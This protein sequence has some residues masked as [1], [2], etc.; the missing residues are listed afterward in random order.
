MLTFNDHHT[1]TL[2]HQLNKEID[3]IGF[4]VTSELSAGIRGFLFF[5]G[6]VLFVFLYCFNLVLFTLLPIMTLGLAGGV[7]GK[8]LRKE[9]QILSDLEKKLNSFIQEKMMQI[10]TVKLFSG[11]EIEMKEFQKQ[12]KMI[13]KQGV[14][15]A[16]IRS[17]FFAVMEFLGENTVIWGLGYGVYL[18]QSDP[19]LNIGKLT[20]FATYAV[21]AG[22]GYRLLADSLSEVIKAS[23]LYSNILKSMSDH[24]DTE[25]VF[26]LTEEYSSQV[27]IEI[28]ALSFTYPGRQV[29]VLSDVSMKVKPG[30]I[31]GLIGASGCG[32]STLFHLLTH[33][34]APDSGKILI[35]SI[36]IS[37]K[38]A[39]WARSFFSIVSQENLLFSN[40]ILENLRYSNPQA[41]FEDIKKACSRADALDFIENLPNKFETLVGENGFNLSGGQRQRICIAR[42]FLK[43]PKILLLDEAT[44]GLDGNSESLIQGILEREVKKRGFT[45]IM[46]THRVNSL[47]E[48]TDFV[49]LMKNG[50][51]VKVGAF[52]E[53]ES[54]SDFL[55]L[56]KV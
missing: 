47:K 41:S 16:G 45:V 17:K 3:E 24:S 33:L 10:K 11:E 53:V 48:L 22:M 7:F 52:A 51:I 28:Q 19:L 42:A 18:M 21:Y 20:A 1:G 27:S 4:V 15:V 23:S 44:S 35:D 54:C 34:Y 40:N 55:T 29:A 56:S 37:K 39:G 36:D 49:A 30:E 31:W 46:I 2:T 50:K 25:E 8:K 12:V 38:P 26:T 13:K 6:G 32:K 43:K 5:A 9:V 14:Q